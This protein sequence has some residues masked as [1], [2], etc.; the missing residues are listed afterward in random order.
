MHVPIS[1]FPVKHKNHDPQM[2]IEFNKMKADQT[3]V[4]HFDLMHQLQSWME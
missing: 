2:H 3:G 4:K 1:K